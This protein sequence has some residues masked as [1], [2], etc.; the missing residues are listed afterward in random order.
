LNL[1]AMSDFKSLVS[2]ITKLGYKWV[3]GTT[4]K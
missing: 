3:D 4:A 1:P 2:G